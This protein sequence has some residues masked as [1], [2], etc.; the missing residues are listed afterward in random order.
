MIKINSISEIISN[1]GDKKRIILVGKGASGKDYARTILEKI[2]YPYQ[3]SYT[4]RPPRS[5]EKNGVDYWFVSKDWFLNMEFW[6]YFYESVEFN[7]WHYGTSREQMNRYH[8]CFIMTPSGISHLNE[9]DRKDSLIVYFDIPLEIRKHRLSQ[10]SDA[11]T[12]ERRLAADEE[13]FKDFKNFDLI[14]TDPNYK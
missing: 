3:I 6:D 8:C 1:L 2:G 7:T 5:N 9:D 14:I 4:T 12:I 10:R 11:D 13:D